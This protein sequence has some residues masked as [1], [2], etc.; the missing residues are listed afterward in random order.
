MPVLLNSK[1]KS[2]NPTHSDWLPPHGNEDDFSSDVNHFFSS[3]ITISFSL[4]LRSPDYRSIEIERDT[5]IA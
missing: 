1:S 5:L 4:P 2:F 3:F